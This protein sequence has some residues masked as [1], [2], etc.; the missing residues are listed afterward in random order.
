MGMIRGFS[1]EN[2]LLEHKHVFQSGNYF[3]VASI[4]L[5]KFIFIVNLHSRLIQSRKNYT[6][7]FQTGVL[8]PSIFY[9]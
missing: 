3:R 6:T 9:I 4:E 5:N 2:H 7:S 8:N 1:E